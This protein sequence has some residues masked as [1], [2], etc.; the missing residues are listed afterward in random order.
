VGLRLAGEAL[1]PLR[2]HIGSDENPETEPTCRVGVAL[3]LLHRETI[4]F[5]RYRDMV[6]LD[7]FQVE[8][9]ITRD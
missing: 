9:V 7:R 4:P 5:D 1:A 8:Q 6:M 3:L 2:K